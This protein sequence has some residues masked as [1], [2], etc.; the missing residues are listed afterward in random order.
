MDNS[1]KQLIQKSTCTTLKTYNSIISTVNR[2]NNKTQTINYES[3]WLNKIKSIASKLISNIKIRQRPSIRPFPIENEDNKKIYYSNK[4]DEYRS[5]ISIIN[6]KIHDNNLIDCKY[7][8][9]KLEDYIS[10][11]EGIIFPYIPSESWKAPSIHG[12]ENS[13]RII[14][15]YYIS[16]CMNQNNNVLR[17][18]YKNIIL[19]DVRNL[20]KLSDYQIKYIKNMSSEDKQEIIEEYNHVIE[21]FLSTL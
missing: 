4:L 8:Q 2:M 10:E 12:L 11:T 17:I 13:P 7:A 15:D 6:K 5:S 3:N 1:N 20:R 19:D 21:S 14:P 18:D 9:D 16:T